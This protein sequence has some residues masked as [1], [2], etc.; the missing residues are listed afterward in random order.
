MPSRMYSAAVR[1]RKPLRSPGLAPPPRPSLE[2]VTGEDKASSQ[3]GSA[4]KPGYAAPRPAFRCL[5]GFAIDPSLATQ[6]DTA[7][8]SQVI[9]KT[10]WEKLD[11]GP[12]GEYL[13]VIDVDP[14]SGCFYEPVDLEDPKLLAQEGLAPS[15]GT[16]Q[17]HQQ[18]VYAVSSLTITHFEHALGRR[19]L[20]RHGPAPDSNP[21]ND[22]VFVPQLRIYPHALRDR[23]A[24][25]SPQKIALLFGYFNAT[26][27]EPGDHLPGGIVF[28]CLSHDVVAHE[29]T[30]A[31]LDGMHRRFLNATNPDVLAFHEAFADVVALFQH[32]TLSEILRQQIISTRGEIA[33]Q[34]NLLGQ[35]AGQFGRAT[36]LRGAL[37]D[38]IGKME[39]GEWKPHKPDPQE[40]LDTLE[41]HARGAILV[42]AI[43]DAFLSIYERRT[44][45]LLRL[46]TGGTGVLRPG[47]IHPDLVNRL[48][49]EA[50]KSAKHVLTICI[51]ALD[52]C[53]PVDITFGEYLRA[54][55]TGDVDLV[56]D[57]DLKYRVAFIEAFRKRGIYPK[58]VR[59]LSEES[60]VWRG[61]E[62]D[63]TRYSDKFE[64]ILEEVR[65]YAQDDLY[66][67][68]LDQRHATRRRL[69]ERQRELRWKMHDEWL[70]PHFASP[71]GKQ[72]AALLGLNPQEP[73][74]VHTAR[75]ALRSRPDGGTDPQVILALLQ[76]KQQPIDPT[77]PGGE[78]MTMEGGCS[79]IADLRRRRVRYCIRKSLNS[80]TRLARQQEFAVAS[81]DSVRATYLGSNL[82]AEPLAALHRGIR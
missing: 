22:S 77:D 62:N 29:T 60:L 10:P 27:D 55:I 30:H 66:T 18:T 65:T 26:T 59:T 57:D 43:F 42:A 63:A 82:G 76:R 25:Y 5:R 45:D 16:P 78:K 40:Y 49:V 28:T 14:G 71:E 41:P 79:I 52:Y 3:T 19:V 36:G 69:F 8:F 35:L 51:R 32:F 33:T 68:S 53:P 24:Y 80:E 23:N 34:E 1:P 9:F 58:D 17:F 6:A 7:P 72:D 70:K 20:W 38:A 61:P 75:F 11:P 44:D 12:S 2:L 54:I 39:N 50:S 74:E 46:S 81:L 13:Q 48:A 56:D 67:E 37:R 21:N 4:L 31:L 64:S 47:A 73:F 15:E